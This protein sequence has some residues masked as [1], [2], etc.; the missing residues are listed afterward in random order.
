MSVETI[1]IIIAAA[2][3]AATIV[4]GLFAVAAWILRHTAQQMDDRFEKVYERFEKVDAQF[5]KVDA[6]FEKV[7]A[8][9]SGLREDLTE[10]K[11]AVARLEGPHPRLMMPPH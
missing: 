6:Q 3:L 9:I 10:V 11:V 5:E 4:G 7:D 2:S 8:Q 1:T